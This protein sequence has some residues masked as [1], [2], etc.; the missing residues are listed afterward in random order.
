LARWVAHPA[1]EL[2][3]HEAGQ[4]GRVEFDAQVT[5]EFLPVGFV[6]SDQVLEASGV[7]VIAVRFEG[8]D[9]AR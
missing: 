6:A 3:F 5:H 2:D 4:G 7:D 1:A 8:G 9:E